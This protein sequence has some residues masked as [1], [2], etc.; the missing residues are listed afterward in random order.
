MKA[1]VLHQSGTNPKF[2][3]FDAPIPNNENEILVNVKAFSLKNVD[4][5]KAAGKHYTSY[6]A[7][8]VVVGIDCAGYW[9]TALKYMPGA[10][11]ECLQNRLW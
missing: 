6:P 3:D 7:F 9:K 5:M 8:P 11:P 10:K 4:R 1:A 2:E